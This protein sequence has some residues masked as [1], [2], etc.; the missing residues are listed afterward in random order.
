MFKAISKTALIA[1]SALLLTQC[2]LEVDDGPISD[3]D[4]TRCVNRDTTI[5][6]YHHNSQIMSVITYNSVCNQVHGQALK[7]DTN[8]LPTFQ[9]TYE[10]GVLTGQVIQYYELTP[11]SASANQV[12]FI[13]NYL[14]GNK[15]GLKVSY[16][17]N[18][19]PKDSINYS[20][21]LS[22][23][24]YRSYFSDGTLR[25]SKEFSMGIPIG[26]HIKYTRVDTFITIDDITPMYDTAFIAQYDTNGTELLRRDYEYYPSGN[27]RVMR[28]YA[29]GLL[30]GDSTLYG[31]WKFDEI[32]Y[33]TKIDTV[34]A[35][36]TTYVTTKAFVPIEIRISP[37]DNGKIHG[38]K[39]VNEFT[40]TGI[41]VTKTC[42]QQGVATPGGCN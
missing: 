24:I 9:A 36:D 3:P 37:Y 6:Q 21:D 25:D 27:I 7:Y 28:P 1:I 19:N 8:G 31:N 41:K 32:S 16:Y 26:N 4:E 12:E 39:I 33:I 14:N 35:T 38:Y 17:S 30:H 5:T 13:A 22:H 2:L 29:I 34:F 10:N 40:G 23:G 18:G 11:V 42:Y 20:Q 15:E